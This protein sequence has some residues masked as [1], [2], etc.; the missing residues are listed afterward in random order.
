MAAKAKAA[1]KDERL[2]TEALG[3]ALSEFSPQVAA[4]KKPEAEIRRLVRRD[5]VR[6]V[7]RTLNYRQVREPV[8]AF[9]QILPGF[10]SRP[11]DKMPVE[12]FAEMA[13][14][15]GFHFKASPCAEE[16]GAALP[17]AHLDATWTDPGAAIPLQL[18]AA[19]GRC[20]H[21]L[22]EL[23]FPAL[24]RY[25]PRSPSGGFSRSSAPPPAGQTV[26]PMGSL[27]AA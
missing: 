16:D 26:G 8:K 14:T 1:S 12:R 24:S 9:S 3:E 11:I 5:Y 15:I 4:W 25:H 19:L 22:V 20:R 21:D 6:S 18:E 23:L 2:V 10:N 17:S 13:T 27:V 7:R